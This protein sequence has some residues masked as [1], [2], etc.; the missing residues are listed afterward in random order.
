[1]GVASIWLRSFNGFRLSSSSFYDNQIPSNLR[2]DGASL[3][4]FLYKNGPIRETR[5]F[6]VADAVRGGDR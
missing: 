2:N 5:A 6:V 4:S 3:R 1:M